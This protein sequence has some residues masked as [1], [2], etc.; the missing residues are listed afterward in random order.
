VD[1]EVTSP[2]LRIDGNNTASLEVIG[3]A[4][5]TIKRHNGVS[6]NQ[7]CG[8]HVHVGIVSPDPENDPAGGWTAITIKK[9]VTLIWVLDGRLEGLVHPFRRDPECGRWCAPV[10]MKSIL[11]NTDLL[12]AGYSDTDE[13]RA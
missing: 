1:V 3:R 8:F 12:T 10:T 5:E 11:A 4:A 2:I 13:F 6:I 7:N 9:L